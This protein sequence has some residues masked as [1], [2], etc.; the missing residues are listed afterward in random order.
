MK[1]VMVVG[2]HGRGY[3]TATLIGVPTG[4]D[5][6]VNG[7]HERIG[8][9]KGTVGLFLRQPSQGLK[10]GVTANLS[11]FVKT[12]AASQLGGY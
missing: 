4:Y 9:Q 7:S 3:L 1:K 12:L 8:R 11:G 5:P 10:N 6:L 2:L